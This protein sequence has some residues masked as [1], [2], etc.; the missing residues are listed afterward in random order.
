MRNEFGQSL[1]Y[2]VNEIKHLMD[3][4]P[5]AAR[6]EKRAQ[7][8]LEQTEIGE[9]IVSGG[10]YLDL[11][12]GKGYIRRR[13]EQLKPGVHVFGCDIADRP[14]RRIRQSSS[15]TF[16]TADGLNLPFP[17]ATFDGVS[18]FFVLHHVP[19]EEQEN[20][21][22]ESIRVVKDSGYIFVAEDTVDPD[23]VKQMEITRRADRRFNPTFGLNRPNDYRS[24]EDWRTMF[25][26]NN[27]TVIRE[28]GYRTGN[29]PHTFFVLK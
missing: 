24:S 16:A 3:F 8:H 11:G 14:T 20:I 29:V 18:L 22:E 28:K 12:C 25:N 6:R 23:D 1:A 15:A 21:V 19:F 9:F 17:D 4:G 10:A 26:R 27:L 2:T 5:L 13:L 7:Y